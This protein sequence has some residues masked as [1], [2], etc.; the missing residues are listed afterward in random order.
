LPHLTKCKVG[1]TFE[2]AKKKRKENMQKLK[3]L[4][5]KILVLPSEAETKTK[6]GIVIPDNIKEKPQEGKVIA[7]GSGKM[8][9]GKRIPLEV[10]VGDKV[11]FSKYGGDEIKVEDKE[12]KIISESD[13]LAIIQ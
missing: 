8:V 12:Y 5:D 6:S 10:V 1:F 13:I 7:V 4:G 3:P 11:I 2:N 9:D